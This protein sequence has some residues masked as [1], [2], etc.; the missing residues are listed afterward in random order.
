[1]TGE[2]LE[3]LDATPQRGRVSPHAIIGQPPEM[4]DWHPGDPIYPVRVHRTATI[5][6]L[7]TVDAGYHA[8]T[9]IGPG[10]WL[11]KRVHVGHDCV[12]GEDCELAPGTTVG[13]GVH[14]GDRCK[15]GINST[16]KPLVTIGPDAVIGAGSVV[17]KDVPAGA[18][19]AGNP[20]RLLRWRDGFDPVLRDVMVRYTDRAGATRTVA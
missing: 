7:C 10:A 3:I 5:S 11:M 19:V 12:V 1:M 17:T 20:A 8:P 18:I 16:I 13:G 14:I 2:F 9:V 6:A 4:R 15:L